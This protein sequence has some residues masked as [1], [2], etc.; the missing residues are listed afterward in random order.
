MFGIIGLV[1]Y[2]LRKQSWAEVVII[3]GLNRVWAKNYFWADKSEF[4]DSG[5]ISIIA[6]GD[7]QH[8]RRIDNK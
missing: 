4:V 2:G 3:F 6:E 5:V 1:V 8:L 7:K